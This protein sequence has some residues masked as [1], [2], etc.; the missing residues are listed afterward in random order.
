MTF[1]DAES[2]TNV[3]E[4][5]PH[6]LDSK[7]VDPKPAVPKQS[8]ALITTNH[9]KPPSNHHHRK[10]FVGGLSAATTIEDVKHYFEQYGKVEDAMLLMDRLTQRHRGF[11]F[12]TFESAAVVERVLE[13]HFHEINS[14]MV[15]CKQ[16]KPKEELSPPPSRGYYRRG[17]L[18]AGL[19]PATYFVHGL[20]G[21]A[22]TV[23]SA[24]GL[25]TAAFLSPTAVDPLTY[26][27]YAQPAVHGSAAVAYDSVTSNVGSDAATTSELSPGSTQNGIIDSNGAGSYTPPGYVMTSGGLLINQS[28]V[29]LVT[30]NQYAAA[31]AAA[32]AA[33]GFVANNPQP[34]A[35]SVADAL[36]QRALRNGYC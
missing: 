25:P 5:G 23:M 4:N 16:A 19:M 30:P 11:A 26:A 12:V 21:Y 29:S 3:L 27:T 20:A 33:G 34:L 24:H 22:P 13:V 14:K 32:A 36:S 17:D 10:L 2:V 9:S 28:L 18:A 8:T 31:A 7:S 6:Q 15:E 35:L 1:A